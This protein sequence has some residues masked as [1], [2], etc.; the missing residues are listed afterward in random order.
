VAVDTLVRRG[1]VD[2]LGIAVGQTGVG[3]VLVAGSTLFAVLEP[4][5][6]A[7]VTGPVANEALVGR[8]KILLCPTS[9]TTGLSFSRAGQTGGVAVHALVLVVPELERGTLLEA[10]ISL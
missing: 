7:L 3:L 9:Q 8:R 4:C 1:E 6:G 10:R 2:L 5:S